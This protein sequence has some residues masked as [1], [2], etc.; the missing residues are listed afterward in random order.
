M[1]GD[2]VEQFDLYLS[3]QLIKRVKHH[4]I[5]TEQSL[6]A[7]AGAALDEYLRAREDHTDMVTTG[8]EAMLLETHNGGATA[9]LA[10]TPGLE[11]RVRHRRAPVEP[12]G[13]RSRG[14]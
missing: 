10:Q 12:P 8:I 3:V 6:S 11:L 9:A 2:E 4:A 14:G 1:A 7:L 13:T 5:D